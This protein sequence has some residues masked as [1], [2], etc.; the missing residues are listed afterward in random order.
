MGS[1]KLKFQGKKKFYLIYSELITAARYKGLV[2]YQEIAKLLGMPLTG[3]NMG[4]TIGTLVGDISRN[5]FNNGRPMLSAIVVGVSGFPGKGF[6]GLAEELGLS[7]EDT[8]EGREIF[9]QEEREKVY[10]AWKV[11]L[12]K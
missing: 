9:W 1:P 10:E 12:E 5:E 11:D 4:R 2:T 7:F 8:P 3:Q 6:Y